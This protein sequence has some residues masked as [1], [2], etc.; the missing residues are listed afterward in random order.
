MHFQF[1][2]LSDVICNETGKKKLYIVTAEGFLRTL[3]RGESSMRTR[4]LVQQE[5]RWRKA[6][7]CA[8]VR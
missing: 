4:L 8:F 2:Q 7:A 1:L 6:R 5:V 3:D